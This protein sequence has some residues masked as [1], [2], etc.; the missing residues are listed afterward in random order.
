VV[1]LADTNPAKLA[2]VA[3]RHPSRRTT[4]APD[5]LLTDPAIDVV[6]IASYDDAHAAQVCT[7]LRHGKHVF[8]EKPLCLYAAEAAAI[9]RVLRARP[10]LRLSS[11]LILRHSP[12]FVWLREALAAGELGEVYYAEADYD[13]GRVEKLTA[14][15]RGQLPFYSVFLGGGVHMVDL[16]L[17]LLGRRPERVSSFANRICTAGTAFRHPDLVAAL[18]QCE[19]GLVAKLTANFGCVRP[20]FHRLTLY[21]TRA[22]FVHTPEAGL[23]Y[24]SRD[25]QQ[26]PEQIAL[27][28]PGYHKGDFL[29]AFVR[30]ILTG[31][32]PAVTADEVFAAM[33]VCF[34][35]EQALAD[36]HATP[37]H[38][39]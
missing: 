30:A 25:P 29:H 7:A 32:Q 36:G 27:P 37:V 26:P 1:A 18:C 19:G 28:Y 5:E 33:S 4:S 13:Y 14:G 9:R 16:L 10:H 6:S 3:A 17:W 31:G 15:W 34:A 22:T 2:E 24:R 35:V 23:L 8:V 39:L 38:Y 11:N 21:G 20:H 12:R